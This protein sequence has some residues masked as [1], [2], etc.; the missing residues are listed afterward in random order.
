M[1]DKVRAAPVSVLPLDYWKAKGEC[2]QNVTPG[3]PGIIQD[4]DFD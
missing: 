3:K 2:E 4:K 1:A